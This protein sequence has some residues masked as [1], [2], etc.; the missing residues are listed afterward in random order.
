M[1]FIE[2]WNSIGGVTGLA[3][4][5]GCVLGIIS[6]YLHW[7]NSQKNIKVVDISG[8]YYFD[9]SDLKFTENNLEIRVNVIIHN[10]KDYPI[11]VTDAVGF[12]K[13]TNSEKIILSKRNS[14][15]NIPQKI[16]SND[17]LNLD[18][19]FYYTINSEKDFNTLARFSQ[20]KFVGFQN[21]VP[22]A[23]MEEEDKNNINNPLRFKLLLHFDGN[24]KI[25]KIVPVGLKDNET[26]SG[27]LNIVDIKEAENKF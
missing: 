16:N 23:I 11:V 2:I 10:E 27:T 13:Q 24:Y 22:I 20:I 7:K 26:N 19:A 21:E 3:S 1:N 8:F 9:D 14:I 15:T 6:I 4:F 12:L 5:V 18:L 17:V 25:E